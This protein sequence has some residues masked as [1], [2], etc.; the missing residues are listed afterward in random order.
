MFHKTFLIPVCAA[1]AMLSVPLS[2]MAEEE[3]GMPMQPANMPIMGG[4][5]PLG[6]P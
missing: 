5:P 4:P 2:G 3:A 6:C 1:A